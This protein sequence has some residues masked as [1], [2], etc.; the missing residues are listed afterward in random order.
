MQV[1]DLDDNSFE[2]DSSQKVSMIESA[3]HYPY[4]GWWVLWLILFYPACIV[5]IIMGLSRKKYSIVFS[6]PSGTRINIWVNE[7]TFARVVNCTEVGL[8]GSL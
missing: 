2:L 4:W 3:N 1:K 8:D 5:L 7:A 6:T